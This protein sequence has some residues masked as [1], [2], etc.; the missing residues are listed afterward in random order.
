MIN[1]EEWKNIINYSKY[2]ISNYGRV[3]SNIG[4]SKILKSFK[5]KRGYWYIGLNNEYGNQKFAISRLVYAH[6]GSEEMIDELVVD[7]KDEDKNNNYI[8]NLQLLTNQ[9]NINKHWSF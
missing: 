4:K 9:E 8:G 7:H 6:F 1:D 5:G 3:K 2:E